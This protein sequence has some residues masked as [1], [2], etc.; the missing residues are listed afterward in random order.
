L[1]NVMLLHSPISALAQN[2]GSMIPVSSQ[3]LQANMRSKA[4]PVTL[5]V[6][7]S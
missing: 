2:N 4:C 3:S 6:S 5:R 7:L 1:S